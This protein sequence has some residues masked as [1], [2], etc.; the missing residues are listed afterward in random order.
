MKERLMLE[1]QSDE[2]SNLRSELAT[3]EKLIEEQ[4][5]EIEVVLLIYS[6]QNIVMT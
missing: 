4:R 6:M 1:D 2:Q 5:K 3:E